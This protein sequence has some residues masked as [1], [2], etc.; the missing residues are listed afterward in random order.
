MEK[1]YKKLRIFTAAPSDVATE[2]SRLAAVVAELNRPENL[3]DFLGLTL[4]VLNWDAYVA[5]LLGRPED[6]VFQQL[7]VETW[8]I[9]IGILWLRFGTPTSKLDPRSGKAFMSGTQ[10]EFSLAYHA[11][12]KNDHPKILLYRCTRMPARLD[13]IDPD[14]YK[15]VQAFFLQFDVNAEHPGFYRSFQTVED[16][17]RSLRQDLAK[18]LVDYAGSTVEVGSIGDAL[19]RYAPSFRDN[20]SVK[21]SQNS[22]SL[23]EKQI[24]PPLKINFEYDIFLSY[25]TDDVAI[26]DELRLS[27]TSRGLRCFMAER[28]IP[29]AAQWDE[30]IRSALLN[31]KSILLLI[32]PRSKDRPWVLL[33]TGAAWA[34]QKEIIPTLMFVAPSDLL[35][36]V[37]HYQARV[38]ETSVQRRTLAEEL[39]N[40]FIV[41]ETG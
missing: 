13:E 4:E 34:L 25:G 20:E 29:V 19:I 27:L 38:V 24:T 22:S 6:V 39:A 30:K 7:P 16:F 35:D 26:A 37:K 40:N 36:P 10:E 32:T 3:A 11:F 2:R 31:S 21:L 28:D 33:E 9:F 17:E 15:R 12:K 41:T 23:P 1:N 5:P 14:Q 18:L 8:D